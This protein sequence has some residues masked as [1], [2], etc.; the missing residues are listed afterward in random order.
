MSLTK[1]VACLW[2][3][4]KSTT[5][6]LFFLCPQKGRLHPWEGLLGKSEKSCIKQ[7]CG[8]H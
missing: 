8:R 3:S 6:N 5:S 2:Q 1:K 4:L 7:T